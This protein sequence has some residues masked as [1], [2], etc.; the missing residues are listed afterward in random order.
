[1]EPVTTVAALLA[2][3]RDLSAQQTFDAEAMLEHLATLPMDAFDTRTHEVIAHARLIAAAA[4]NNSTARLTVARYAL[5]QLVLALEHD[6][7]ASSRSV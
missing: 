1:M 4:L 2:K 3:V 5:H 7:A 6:S